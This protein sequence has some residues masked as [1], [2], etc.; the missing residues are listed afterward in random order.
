MSRRAAGG[1]GEGCAEW[2]V[3]G[4]ELGGEAGGEDHSD[5]RVRAGGEAGGEEVRR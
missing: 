5:E 1:Q 2:Q 3:S 4:E